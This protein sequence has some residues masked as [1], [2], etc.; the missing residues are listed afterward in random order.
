MNGSPSRLRVR[1][2]VTAIDPGPG[3]RVLPV[4]EWFISRMLHDIDLQYWQG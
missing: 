4:A 2:A 1:W 3:P